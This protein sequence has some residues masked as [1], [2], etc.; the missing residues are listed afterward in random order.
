MLPHQTSITSLIED[1]ND[2]KAMALFVGTGIDMTNCYPQD[3]YVK[4]EEI[5]KYQI[6]WGSLLEELID[7]AGIDEKE[8]ESLK[9]FTNDLQAAILKH[10]LGNSYI[11]IIQTWLYKRCNRRVLEDAYCFYDNFRH[12]LCELE[13]V[14]FYSLFVVAETILLQSSIKTVVTQNYDNFLT[15]TI[16]ILIENNENN[17]YPYRNINAIDVYDG[18]MDEKLVENTFL[19]Y[20]VHGF[21]PPVSELR[22]KPES[23]HIVLSQEEFHELGQHVYSW[24]NST[25]LYYLTH[26]T[27]L[28]LGLS[29]NDLTSIRVLKYADVGKNSEKIYAL[30]AYDKDS[31]DIKKHSIDLK[32]AYYETQNIHVIVEEN[33]FKGFYKTIRETI[34]N[35]I[36]K[37]GN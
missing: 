24:Q 36:L 34:I 10:L 26:Y 25:Q 27:C 12:G 13:E 6:T 31:D 8:R 19:I 32:A 20:H 17:Q 28:F 35:K 33:G 23:N 1:F 30:M 3:Y 11:P 29:L 9:T 21:I 15:E 4:D 2:N 37:H 7:N 16:K 5:K 22:P 18:W 14:P